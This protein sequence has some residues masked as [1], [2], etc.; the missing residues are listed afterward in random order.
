MTRYDFTLL[1]TTFDS[2]IPTQG[3]LPGEGT[4]EHNSS[5]F[6]SPSFTAKYYFKCSTS[7]CHLHNDMVNI[8]HIWNWY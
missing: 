7:G 4:E 3:L 5:C 2:Y 8:Q 6:Y 1:I